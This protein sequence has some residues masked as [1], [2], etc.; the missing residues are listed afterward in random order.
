M[1]YLD[2]AATSWPKPPEVV[3]AMSSFLTEIGAS[4][5]RGGHRKAME[6]SRIV[7]ETRFKLANLLNAS[8]PSRIVFTHNATDALNLAIKGILSPGDEVITSSIEHNSVMRPLM[9]LSGQGVK[10][11]RISCDDQGLLNVEELRKSITPATRLIV[12]THASNVIGCLTPVEEVGRMAKE[13]GITFLIDAAQTLGVYPLDVEQSYADLVAFPGH[14]GLLGPQGT[15]GLY[16]REGIDLKT[17]R[18]GGTGSSSDLETQ[19]DL[20]PDRYESGTVNAVGLAG[21]KAGVEFIEKQGG[22][23]KIREH[24]QILFRRIWDGLKSIPRVC[25]YGPE[26]WSK[27]VGVISFNLAGIGSSD[28]SQILD[29]SFDIATRSALHC[30]PAAHRTLNTLGQGTVRASLGYFNTE[31]DA[32][33]LVRAVE[34]ISWAMR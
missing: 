24:E 20:L 13:A 5:G 18:E 31:E 27:R 8:D 3:E 25:L 33:A 32:E 30:S 12:L 9:A 6:A 1:V 28:V 29:E 14:K 7:F 16:I 4:P 10:V 22:V 2:N 15:G 26:E 17:L 23:V 19:P 34:R 21:L 11:N